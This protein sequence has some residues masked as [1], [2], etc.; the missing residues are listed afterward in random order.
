M[1]NCSRENKNKFV[2]S[3]LHFLVKS[4]TFNEI[5]V[6][7]LPVGHTHED[8]D[9]LF[10]RVSLYMERNDAAT[11][12][13]FCQCVRQAYNPTPSV[14]QVDN[15]ANIQEYMIQNKWMEEMTGYFL[16]L[17]V[18]GISTLRSFKICWHE[19]KLGLFVKVNSSDLQ[20]KGN[21]QGKPFILL[22]DGAVINSLI[23]PSN[24]P[25]LTTNDVIEKI[26]QNIE[27]CKERFSS[28]NKDKIVE[29]LYIQLESIRRPKV[30]RFQW[31]LNIYE[32][33]INFTNDLDE[34]DFEI[35]VPLHQEDEPQVTSFSVGKKIKSIENKIAVVKNGNNF[36]ITIQMTLMNHLFG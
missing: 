8:I 22:K 21:E 16:M 4:G 12:Q 10:S 23:F 36:E 24:Y 7:F 14:I 17:C 30:T 20:W 6:S 33:C 18:L 2:L 9:Q 15:I 11:L 19:N 3:Y 27:S 1:D 35:S 34:D 25:K 28:V 5:I 26:E 32:K 31:N 29:D 13:E